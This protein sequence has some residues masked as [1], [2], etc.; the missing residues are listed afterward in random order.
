MPKKIGRFEIVRVL[1]EGSQGIVHLARDP[2]LER[3]VA[4]KTLHTGTGQQANQLNDLLM[5]EAK[6]I[7]KMTHP[8]IVSIFE[9]GEEKKVPFLVFEYIKGQTLSEVIRAREYRK[10]NDI[11]ALFKPVCLGIQHSHK[12]KIIHGDLKPANIIL[13]EEN[14]AKVMDFGIARLL[15]EQKSKDN[16]YG[17]PR[18]MPPEYLRERQVSEANDVFA[19]GLI[20]YELITGSP[21]FQGRDLKQIIYNVFNSKIVLPQGYENKEYVDLFEQVILKATEKDRNNRFLSM[22]EMLSAIESYEKQQHVGGGGQSDKA[23]DAAITFL[24]RKMNRK[25]DFPALSETLVKINSLVDKDD[26]NSSE[27]ANVIAEDFA[28]TNKILK[29]VNSAYYRGA[30]PEITTLSQAVLM[31]GFDAV[32]SVAISLILI[33]HLH[34]KKQAKKMRS[35]IVSSIYSGVLTKDLSAEVQLENLEEAF[36]SGTF[37]QLGELLALYYFQEEAEEIDKLRREQNLTEDQ[38]SRKILGVTY[39]KLA[40]AIAEE[41]KL[42]RYIIDNIPPYKISDNKR[43]NLS[44]HD[45][46]RA[47]TTLSNALSNVLENKDDDR[48][49]FN[50]VKLWKTFAKDLNLPDDSMVK[51]ADRARQNLVEVNS[52]YNIDLNNS[53]VVNKVQQLAYEEHQRDDDG[54]KTLVIETTIVETSIVDEVIDPE[55]VLKKAT[56]EIKEILNSHYRLNDVLKKFADSVHEALDLERAIFCLYNPKSFEMSARYGLG[57][58]ASFLKQFTFKSNKG[59]NVF[60]VSVNKGVDIFINDANDFEKKNTLP[61]WYRQIIDAETFIL[62]PF[63]INKKPFGL[64]Y[65]DKNKKNDLVVVQDLLKKVQDLRTLCTS[66]IEQKMTK[67]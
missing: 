2:L 48:W 9:A 23:Q 14:I 39:T 58:T 63:T 5:D 67:R 56:I 37:H 41:W 17:T 38:A 40:L 50:A 54:D 47:V 4:I 18:Y 27:L 33:D 12:N 13:D 42:P 34:N 31:L 24:M 57:I 8:N 21:A 59:N 55:E 10:I 52:I 25:Q 64:F 19:M 44:K 46:L 6:V 26:T 43:K 61:P 3:R 30:K 28:L 29:L 22:S 16:L 65:A 45:K 35:H 36:L 11:L 53:D 51:I 20:L 32:R 7:S 1:G 66:G 15:S 62:L 49:R 60:Q